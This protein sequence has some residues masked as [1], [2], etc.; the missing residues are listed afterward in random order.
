[1]ITL[2]TLEHSKAL[3]SR[4]ENV[5]KRLL[6]RIRDLEERNSGLYDELMSYL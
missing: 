3:V 4:Q 2:A 1:M 5:N 6:D